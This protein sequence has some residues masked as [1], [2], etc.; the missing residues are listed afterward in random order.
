VVVVQRI[1]FC[2]RPYF[3][4]IIDGE[5]EGQINNFRSCQAFNTVSLLWLIWPKCLYYW[6]NGNSVN[7]SIGSLEYPDLFSTLSSRK[8]TG[9]KT[10]DAFA[11]GRLSL[12]PRICGLFNACHRQRLTSARHANS[13]WFTPPPNVRGATVAPISHLNRSAASRA[14]HAKWAGI[15]LW[16]VNFRQSVAWMSL[17]RRVTWWLF[18]H[19]TFHGLL[20]GSHFIATVRPL[21]PQ[22]S[23]T[24]RKIWVT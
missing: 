14:L 13:G 15:Y 8:F 10:Y 18:K 16:P 1:C 4:F 19:K 21:E 5:S 9:R 22:V 17:V 6:W 24:N 23:L 20:R 11:D 3:P 7:D 12:S 2:F